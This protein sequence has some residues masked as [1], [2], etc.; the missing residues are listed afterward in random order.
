M[1]FGRF[2]VELSI[3]ICALILV[4]CNPLPPIPAPTSADGSP[5]EAPNLAS[6]SEEKEAAT[7][8][9]RAATAR[10]TGDERQA[11]MLEN[12]SFQI[13]GQ[14]RRSRHPHRSSSSN[15]PTRA[16]KQVPSTSTVVPSFS[17]PT[18]RI[19]IPLEPNMQ[20]S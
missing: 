18:T 17:A 1:T 9:S 8:A 2:K 3:A 15:G 7:I 5:I 19:L 14:P 16:T 13:P 6:E 11:E 12:E 10:A 4:A 20:K